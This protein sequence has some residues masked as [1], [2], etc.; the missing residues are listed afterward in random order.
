MDVSRVILL[1]TNKYKNG[2]LTMSNREKCNLLLDSFD[3]AQL[4][5]I[6]AMLQA[7]KDIAEA[8]DDAFCEE[9][10]QNYLNDTSSDR[11]EY[12]T[13]EEVCKALGVAL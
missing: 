8:A 1:K 12:M 7:V 2:G 5:N 6:A 11:D 10:Y 13:E 4:V 9:L 3:E